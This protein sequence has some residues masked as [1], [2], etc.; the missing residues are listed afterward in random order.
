MKDAYIGNIFDPAKRG[1]ITRNISTELSG[2]KKQDAIDWLKNYLETVKFG[3][4]R[5]TKT[6]SEE[7]LQ[8]M[9]FIGLYQKN[10]IYLDDRVIP[11]NIDEIDFSS[12]TELPN[13]DIE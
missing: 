2:K 6:Y 4:P 9:G 5:A 1:G 10:P 7:K 3:P 12:R 13:E 8:E 11:N